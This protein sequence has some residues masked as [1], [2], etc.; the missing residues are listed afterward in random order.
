MKVR[1]R[2]AG[3]L[4]EGFRL[5]G[6][7]VTIGFRHVDSGVEL[8]K[9]LRSNRRRDRSRGSDHRFKQRSK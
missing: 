6:G 9:I 2:E 5:H 8:L 3:L 1:L 4:K 7:H